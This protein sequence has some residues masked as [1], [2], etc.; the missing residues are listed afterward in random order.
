MQTNTLSNG[1][2]I[3][4]STFTG[5]VLSAEKS[6][7]T[8]I[9]QTA[10]TVLSKDLV[11]PGTVYSTTHVSQDVWLRSSE[12]AEKHVDI[13]HIGL[14]IRPGHIITV[15]WGQTQHHD[16]GNY[17]AARN[18]TIDESRCDVMA[19][20]GDGMKD[21]KLRVGAGV[22]LFMWIAGFT[23]GGALIAGLGTGD[24]YYNWA[25]KALEHAV[26]GGIG[27]VI[28]GFF[29]GGTVGVNISLNGKVKGLLEEI[30]AFT[31]QQLQSVAVVPSDEKPVSAAP[32]IAKP[33]QK[34][35]QRQAQIDA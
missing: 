23:L 29:L 16:K 18:H 3:W 19:A 12:G 5:E 33:I 22:H 26:L 10:A 25:Q 21:W 7:S 31:R 30:N 32:M 1:Q 20:L 2:E 9:H 17:F 11:I 15:A 13:G 4:V 35:V 8:S 27:G 24:H 34:H 28:V 6:T 14:S